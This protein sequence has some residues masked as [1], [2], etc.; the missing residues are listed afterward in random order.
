M[1]RGATPGRNLGK[2]VTDRLRGAWWWTLRTVD[3]NGYSVTDLRKCARRSQGN[4]SSVTTFHKIT[5]SGKTD[6]L[7]TGSAG[8]G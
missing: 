3:P 2:E 1:P 8:R 4:R 5:G 7:A 6:T